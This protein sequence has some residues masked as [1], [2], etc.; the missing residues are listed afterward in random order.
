M[1]L[2]TVW[3]LTCKD[4][5]PDTKDIK[6]TVAFKAR[7]TARGD[8]VP[9][10]KINPDQIHS[11]TIDT[12][13]LRTCL[14]VVAGDPLSQYLAGDFKGAYL[15]AELDTKEDPVFVYVPDGMDGVP[16][17]CVLQLHINLY[18]LC[19][20]AWRWYME[21]SRTLL[22]LGW[23]RGVFDGCLWSRQD[24]DGHTYFLVHVDDTLSLGRNVDKHVAAI[25]A[26]Y[27][28]RNLGIPTKWCGIAFEFLPKEIILHQRSYKT[29]FVQRWRND[30][31]HPMTV[32]PHLSA[33]PQG[34]DL[35]NLAQLPAPD[36]LWYR[37]Y[38]GEINWMQVTN[39]DLAPGSVHLFRGIGNTTA[40]HAAAAQ[41]M[42]G[43]ISAHLDQ[44]ISFSRI[45]TGSVVP[46]MYVDAEFA[47]N[48]RTGRSDQGSFITIYDNPVAWS[49]EAQ[50]SVAK[51][52]YHAEIIAFS[53]GGEKLMKIRNYLSDLQ[54]PIT[55]P[56]ITYEDNRAVIR[57][58]RDIGMARAARSLVIHFHYGRDLQQ[59]GY[60]DIR[61]VTSQDNKA[62]FFTKLQG[63]E[64]FRA[65][66]KGMHIVSLDERRAAATAVIG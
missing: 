64:Q 51:N 42:L 30:P 11:P 28:L 22:V 26:K 9:K 65:S 1:L 54:I 46:E 55:Q 59:Q 53:G 5:E 48:R 10:D 21:L 44:G 16:T 19:E 34:T 12:D 61:G 41:H 36:D 7:L 40:L 23:N 60:I 24:G 32:E 8:L 15:N 17:G 63:K 37:K 4:S 2:R 43:Y 47:R 33:L 56:S 57:Y 29:H 49:C 50:T 27:E 38:C 52:S 14:A 25:A 31:V 62:D 20:A 18:G 35:L 3:V 66:C 13:M 39:P 45:R 58:G 6:T